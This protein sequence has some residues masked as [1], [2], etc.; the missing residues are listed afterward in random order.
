MKY[1]YNHIRAF[2]I[3]VIII[4]GFTSC[5]SEDFTS[6]NEAG[7]PMASEYEDGI[8]I[9]VNQETNWVTFS[10]SGK[11]GVVPVWIIDGKTYSSSFVMKKYYRKAGDYSVDIK[12]SNSNGIS[13]GSLTKAFHI[14]KTIMNGFGGFV[15]DSDFN[16]WKKAIIQKPVFWYAPKWTQIA[17]PSYTLADGTYS[18]SLPVATTDTW[19]SQMS[20]LTDISTKTLSEYDFS[21]ILTSTKD[22]PHVTV[23]LVD[24]TNDDKFYFVRAIELIANEPICFFE[25][26]LK[27]QDIS[28]LKLV[29][30]FGGNEAESDVIVEN[31][32]F[33]DHANDDGTIVPEQGE[34]EP[35]W[36][37]VTSSDNLWKGVTFTEEYFYAPDWTQIAD[38]KLTIS[39]TVY[40]TNFPIA[41]SDTWQNQIKLITDNLSIVSTENY[42]FRVKIN[43]S[44]DIKGA[45]IKL[46]QSDNDE[47]FLFLQNVD[48]LGG[49]DIIVKAIKVKGVDIPKVKL[50]F[51]F[52]RNPSDTDLEIKDII[53]QI[54]KD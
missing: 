3:L 1:I 18:I 16:L 53:L 15:Y 19:Q 52:G 14:N 42:D 10:F 31:I 6:P 25:S 11:K 4:S 8:K 35:I 39:G 41:T 26:E 40:S 30:D 27:G 21:V 38:P 44:K 43:V 33:K 5:S 45:T 34:A 2:F 48:L 46:A 28:N 54:H 9:D 17:D 47:V 20:M 7:I 13:D 24:S 50:V 36:V 12:I 49:E 29:L 37:D 22:H 51:D 23:K 32:V